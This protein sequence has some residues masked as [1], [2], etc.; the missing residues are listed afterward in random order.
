M[1][2]LDVNLEPATITG[3]SGTAAGK[4]DDRVTIDAA[5]DAIKQQWHHS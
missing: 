1:P 4:T 5:R 3:T 2:C